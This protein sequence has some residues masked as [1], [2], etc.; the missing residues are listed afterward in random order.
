MLLHQVTISFFRK[1]LPWFDR[2]R[3]KSSFLAGILN[4][5]LDFW[6]TM[7]LMLISVS[8]TDDQNLTLILS[9]LLYC[10]TLVMLSVMIDGASN[11]I[12]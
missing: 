2:L 4:F 9:V 1:R 10:L 8:L 12:V 7:P 11:A 5:N 3:E 6:L